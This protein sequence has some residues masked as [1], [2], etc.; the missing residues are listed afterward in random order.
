[1]L[2]WGVHLN[3]TSTTGNSAANR[4]GV[5]DQHESVQVG[6]YTAAGPLKTILVTPTDCV[7]GLGECGISPDL[8]LLASKVVGAAQLTGRNHIKPPKLTELTPW[9]GKIWMSGVWQL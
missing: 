8:S 5:Q 9:C 2:G 6:E 3:L 7:Y 1:M 4:V